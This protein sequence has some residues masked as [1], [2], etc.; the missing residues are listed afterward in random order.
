M[1]PIWTLSF[2]L[3]TLDKMVGA[4]AGAITGFLGANDVGAWFAGT[5]LTWKYMFS[6]AGIASVFSLFKSITAA[7][8]GISSGSTSFV[9]TSLGGAGPSP[10]PPIPTK[11]VP[12]Q[13]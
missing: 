5:H 11:D 7:T 9:P 6:V 13:V 12:P 8:S 1:S 4:F 3:N 2:W 10:M